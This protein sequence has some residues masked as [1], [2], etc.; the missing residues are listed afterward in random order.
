MAAATADAFRKDGKPGRS[1]RWMTQSWLVSVFRHCTE[2]PI[3]IHGKA[4][5][6]SSLVCPN[7]SALAAFEASAKRGDVG[8]HA[9]P[10]NAEPEMLDASLFDAGLNMTF[11]Q[12]DWIGHAHRMTLSQRDVPGLTRA[13]IPLLRARGVKAITVGENGA[14]APVAV[15]KIF[16]Y[17]EESCVSFILHPVYTLYTPSLPHMHLCAPVIHVYTTYIHVTHL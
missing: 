4:N 10:F 16:M 5:E 3:N 15:P 1:Y 7:A 9:F 12:D 11:E 14:C 8:W 6:P 17:V 13:A 2:S